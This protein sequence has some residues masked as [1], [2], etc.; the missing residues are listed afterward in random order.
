MLKTY[1]KLRNDFINL[2]P[3]I[4]T[5]IY[6]FYSTIKSILLY[7]AD[8]WGVSNIFTKIFFF[9]KREVRNWRLF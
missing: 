5:S 8:I 9:L 1:Y 4:K 7:N 2:N 6:V 3:G